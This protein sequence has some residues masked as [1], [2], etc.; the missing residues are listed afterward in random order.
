MKLQW[1]Q[2]QENWRLL[3]KIL[4]I[5]TL[6]SSYYD[7]AANTIAIKGVPDPLDAKVDYI[8]VT[9]A[10]KVNGVLNWYTSA[11]GGT[12]MFRKTIQSCRQTLADLLTPIPLVPIHTGQSVQLLSVAVLELIL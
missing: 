7:W 2:Q 1:L 12:Y 9:V 4:V 5:F 8:Q 6:S 10:A 3:Q 11:V